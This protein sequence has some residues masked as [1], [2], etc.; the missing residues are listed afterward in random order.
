M[1]WG[2]QAALRHR[3]ERHGVAGLNLAEG[4]LDDPVYARPALPR[5]LS[6]FAFAA[7]AGCLLMMPGIAQAQLSSACQSINNNLVGSGGSNGP[8]TLSGAYSIGTGSPTDQLAAL[9]YS[10]Y[11]QTFTPGERINYSWSK[12][13][14]G[15]VHV[16]LN[17]SGLNHQ[18]GS[19]TNSTSL[20]GSGSI[21]VNG[22]TD[23]LE[24]S[25][26]NYPYNSTVP[27]PTR[28]NTTVNFSISCTGPAP[29]TVTGLSPAVGTTAGGTSVTITGTNFTGVT[30]V[31]FGA[32]AASFTANSATQ[33]TATSPPQAAGTV[34]V[35]VTTPAGTSATAAANQF[36]FDTPP[37]APVVVAPANGAVIGSS[38]PTYAGTGPASMT[39]TVYVDGSAIGTTTSDAAGN[40]TRVQPT[41]LG[42]GPHTVRA[43]ATSAA[44][45]VSPDSNTNSFTVTLPPVANSFTAPAATY[46]GGSAPVTTFSAAAHATN[47]P[48]S[49]AVG[50]PTT[51]NGG[52]V[53]IDSAGLISYTPPAGFRG[54]DS[55]TYTATNAGGTSSPATVTV[56]VS[57]PVLSISLAGSGVRGTPLAGVQLVTT[58]GAA[59]YSCATT[60]AS[61]TLPAGTQLN[62]DCTLSG[63][64]AASGPFN[65]TANV[66]DSSTG[67]GPFTQ[68]SAPLTLSIAS[69]ALSIAPAAGALPGTSAGATYSQTLSASGGSSPYTYA[70]TGG[71]LPTGITLSTDGTLS[72]TATAVGNFAFTVTATDSSSAGSGGPY[73]VAA[74]YTLTVGAPTIA[75]S[76]ATLADPA[77][78]VP[79]SASVSASGGTGSYTY[80][81]VGSLPPGLFFDSTSGAI[82]GTPTS[83]G[84]FTFT[85]RAE[86]GTTG[87]GAPYS[88]SRSYTVSVGAPTIVLSPATLVNATV[89]QSYS[90]TITANGGTPG[91]TYSA[92][93]STLPPGLTLAANGTLS[94]V[95]TAGGSFTFDV[96]AT[97]NSGG[98]GP[99][100]GTRSYTL[101]VNAPTIAVG[102]A[103]LPNPTAG[104]PY[105]EALTASG[106][107][108]GYGFAVTSGALPAGLSISGNAITGT[109]TAG[110]TFTFTITATDSSTGTGAPYTGSRAYTLTVGAATIQ[111][112]PATLPNDLAGAM[113][114]QTLTASG[115]NG[116]YSYAVTAGALPPGWSLSP[117]GVLSGTA[118]ATGSVNFTIT[119]TDQ[120]T[121]AG[122]P[123]SGSR[124]YSVVL[125]SPNL[126]LA[127][128]TLSATAG[129]AYSGNFVAGGGT[130]PYTYSVLNPALLPPGLTMATDGTLSGTPT[131]TGTFGFTVRARDSTTGPGSP[132]NVAGFYTFTVSAPTAPVAGNVSVTVAYNSNANPITLALSGAA[133]TSMAVASPPS[134]GSAVAIG[135]DIT[136]TPASGYFGAD[137]FTYTASNAGGTSAP[138]T[139]SITVSPPP[140]PTV[141]NVSDVPVPFESSG[142]AIDLSGS[143]TGV[144]ASIALA[145]APAHGTVSIA[146]DV[147]TYTPA[148]GYFGADSFTYTATGP[149][150]TSA[151]ATVT[152]TVAT[153]SAPVVA[154]LSD[155]AIPYA[156]SGTAIDLSGSITG[157]HTSI[158]VVTAPAHGATSIAG[159]VVTY[160]PAAGYFGADSFTYTATGPGGTSAPA[161]VSLSVATPAAPT[162][163]NLSGVAIPYGGGGTA[164]DLSGSISGVHTSIAVATA[165][166]HGATSIAGDVITYTPATGYFGTDSF[167]YTATGPG[168]TSTAA[169]VTLTV[170]LPPAPTAA[171]HSGTIVLYASTGT[172]IDLSGSVAG[173]HTAIAVA[174]PPAHGTATVQ[175]YAITYVPAAGYFGDDSFT[176][177]VTGPGGTSAAAT[178]TLTVSLPPAP[179]ATNLAD[180]A[181]AHNSGGT[182]I[183]LTSAIS[184][185]YT[186]VAVGAPPPHGTVSVSGSVVTY[187][188]ATDY[189]G[190][191]SFTY[192]AAGPGGTSAAATVTLAVAL[193]PPPVARST[194]VS[195][196]GSTT[197]ANS[198][199]EIDLS[200][201]VDGNATSVQIE[202]QPAHGTVELLTG[203]GAQPGLAAPPA[204]AAQA[205]GTVTA[206]YTPQPGFHG[207]DS[208]RFVAVGPGGSSS[209]AAVNITVIGVG[210]VALDKTA[211]AG[212]GETVSVDLTEGATG[213]PFTGATVVSVAPAGSATTEVVASGAGATRSYALRITPA[214]RFDGAAVIRYTLSNEFGVSAPATITV[215]VEAR[216]DPTADPTV[217]AV[218]DAQAESTRRFAQSQIENFMQRTESLHNGGGSSDPNMGVR[219]QALDASRT[220][221]EPDRYG[222]QATLALNN[223]IRGLGGDG[224]AVDGIAAMRGMAMPESAR[225]A[226]AAG[227]TAPARSSDDA[228]GDGERRVGSLAF[229][230]GGAIEIGT[231]DRT[232][233]RSKISATSSG[234]SGGADIKLAENLVLGI[235]GGWGIDRSDID[236]DVA[237]VRS[238][239][240]IVAAYGSFAPVR[241]LFVDGVIATGD[242]DFRTQRIVAE[243]G[244]V[245][246]GVRD[247]SMTFGALSLGIDR[248]D[249]DLRWSAYGRGEWLT[250]QLGTYAETGAGRMNLRFDERDVKSL[251][252]VLGARFDFTRKT[253]FATVTPRVR[254]E[255]RHEFQDTGIQFLDYADIPGPSQY[256]IGTTGWQRDQF[257]LSLGS[258]LKLP[259]AWVFDL[260]MALRGASGERSGT[261]R[262]KVSKEF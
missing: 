27:E 63:T 36:T 53:S 104:V 184:G 128:P 145:T 24:L 125:G 10:D 227:P 218:S 72:G 239:N 162:A 183:D 257:E 208:F 235:G 46:N 68:A 91:Y 149:G 173:V 82:T 165:P 5:S 95:P 189:Y 100:T 223:R 147:V 259:S 60:L 12:T 132:F 129:Q 137:S 188:P 142:T 249:G 119:A 76:P 41:P 243:T 144:H 80:A 121:G 88:G 101:T 44:G 236:G 114:S 171:N 13:G 204:Q 56:P 83:G 261:L 2:L 169:T 135:T 58:G 160:T 175:G 113:Y 215:N 156:S 230:A 213:G 84:S 26:T 9:N 79:Y 253:E 59:P 134:H 139:V 65:F 250:A 71:T 90:A 155:V 140:A 48:T 47:S 11:S 106:G 55:F 216:P 73:T 150:G 20:S 180:V 75:L 124:A 255:W 252:G 43:T 15:Y 251:S 148:A 221:V 103:S 196:P 226:A 258:T 4:V 29:P 116:T 122:A 54:N 163:A 123:Y 7:V 210:P 194:D 87:P 191:D 30:A 209:P 179:V 186:S 240:S 40:W 248:G 161:T 207:Q 38:T 231:Q 35:R 67:T 133:A 32:T 245:A 107:T 109:P 115:G 98:S 203:G 217:R 187:T 212:D 69:P 81:V 34:N 62:S 92:V 136:Y 181:V 244:M 166:A 199:L 96:T 19:V 176:F 152:L 177:T 105:N 151:P 158:A 110:G 37:A 229:W 52:T 200:A 23:Y 49:Y 85:I 153:P 39:I 232:T 246:R 224:R 159:D 214:A 45:L 16:V 211:T 202:T 31:T 164:I 28:N 89:G 242:L 247:G 33:I 182:A 154:N 174:A 117:G 233:G 94:G 66:T 99:F 192:T 254:A 198:R 205:L 131:S 260:E 237:H 51:A 112:M 225:T 241:G 120:S 130:A 77:I 178:V 126:T 25:V 64:P 22:S 234:L 138:A 222:E 8:S 3:S 220:F 262:A 172:A 70:V 93:A 111:I 86:D 74:G 185:V 195:T 57:N 238:E 170:G 146:G 219:L 190:A 42:A 18:P 197:V 1:V 206:V 97:D 201:L 143:I 228:S 193:P 168:G 21:T 127:A 17:D 167:T 50:S 14:T 118:T 157:V 102:P 6:R 61:G 256:S 108:A 78:G 141:S